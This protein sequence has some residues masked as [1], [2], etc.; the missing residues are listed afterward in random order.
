MNLELGQLA[1]SVRTQKLAEYDKEAVVI[2]PVDHPVNYLYWCQR[3]ASFTNLLTIIMICDI[4]RLPQNKSVRYGICSSPNN[5][6]L[7]GNIHNT[8]AVIQMTSQ[9]RPTPTLIKFRPLASVQCA[10][11]SPCF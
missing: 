4:V 2:H 1:G 3:A 9:E 10:M 5:S 6:V 8:D 11:F 7:V